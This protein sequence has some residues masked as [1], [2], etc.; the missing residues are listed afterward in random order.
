MVPCVEK[1]VIAAAPVASGKL[2]GVNVDVQVRGMT[3]PFAVHFQHLIIPE[4]MI[5][6]MI[7]HE[8]HNLKIFTRLN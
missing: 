7:S 6:F 2:L 4:N 3:S 8:I 5:D 1:G